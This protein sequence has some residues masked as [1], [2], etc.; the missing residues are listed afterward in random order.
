MVGQKAQYPPAAAGPWAVACALVRGY[1]FTPAEV[2]R[3]VY[4]RTCPLVGRDILLLGGV[5]PLRI[6]IGVRGPPSS[7]R[8]TTASAPGAGP[9]RPWRGTCSAVG[10]STG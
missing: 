5:G 1:D 7:T 3:A 9:I 6:A 8:P 4:D 2:L 10:S